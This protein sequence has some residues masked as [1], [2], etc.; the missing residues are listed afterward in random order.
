M[1]DVKNILRLYIW[2]TN[3]QYLWKFQFLMVDKEISML[4]EETLMF[5][6][7]VSMFWLEKLTVWRKKK[8]S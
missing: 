7:K 6:G 5:D 1:F 3:L 4:Y 2:I 8:N